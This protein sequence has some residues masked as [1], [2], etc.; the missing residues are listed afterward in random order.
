MKMNAADF[1]NYFK[2][3]Y[4]LD[5]KEFTINNLLSNKYPFKWFVNGREEL[6]HDATPLIPYTNKKVLDLEKELQLYQYEFSLFYGCFFIVGKNDNPLFSTEEKYCAPLLLFPA[7]I[8]TLDE[9]KFLKIDRSS[10]VINRTILSKLHLKDERISR[11]LFVQELTEIVDSAADNSIL[12]KGIFDKFFLNIHTDELNLFPAVWSPAKIKKH[13]STN[14][15]SDDQFQI[16]PAAGTILIN[17]SESSLKVIHDLDEIAQENTFN[18]SLHELLS[19][20][21]K[22]YPPHSSFYK[23]RLNTD[24]Y[25]ALQN[26]HQFSN[27]VIVGPPGTGK[28]YTITSIVADAVLHNQSVLIVSKTKQAVEVLR[29]MLQEDFNLKNYLIHTSGH[30]YKISLKS[31][32][33]KYLSGISPRAIDRSTE[34][35]L[36]DLF[37]KLDRLE[38]KFEKF[39]KRELT[40]TE[41]EQDD[42]LH[43]FQKWRKLYLKNISED[44]EKL[45]NYFSEINELLVRIQGQVSTFTMKKI[46][47]NINHHAKTYRKDLSLFLDAL[48]SAS[49][50]EY[51]RILTD[52]KQANILKVFPVWL[53]NLSELNSVLPLE[54]DLFDLVIIDEATQCDVATALPALY[55]AKRSVVVGDPNQ[56]RHYSFVSVQQQTNLH[57]EFNLPKDR[58]FDYR[59]KSILDVFISKVPNQQQISFL[60]EHFRSTPS[61]IEFSNQHFYGGQLEVMKSTPEYANASQIAIID[62]HG[63]RSEKGINE[64]EAHALLKKLDELIADYT[65]HQSVPSI[66]IVS[67]FSSQ[68]SFINSLI[69][70]K[71]DL[72]LLKKFNLLCGTP[73]NFQ[74]AERDIVLI[75]FCVCDN[76]H[77]SA[78][79]HASKAEVLNVA[80]T[81]AKSFQYIFKSVAEKNMKPNSLLRQYFLFINQYTPDAKTVLL[82]DAFQQRVCLA[83][84]EKGFN[85]IKTG[86][87]IAGN[88]LDIFISH[89]N[90]NYFIDLIGYPGAY[91]DAFSMERYRTLARTGIKSMP[92]H[93]TFWQKNPDKALEKLIAF[94]NSHSFF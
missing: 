29:N 77:A 57:S 13:L 2:E 62:T 43:L 28:T 40:I 8:I 44:S 19:D 34:T 1:Y 38:L 17:K 56:L 24:Q 71:Y 70:E 59:N 66:G 69:K 51:K 25:I 39:V 79:L 84:E 49:F 61:L 52:V 30:S 54:R 6:Y 91:K 37:D 12:I 58:I 73:Y 80:I 53:A 78:F 63:K 26:A 20:T 47:E 81:R 72:A 14:I 42:R 5:N 11:D 76:T 27:S 64:V 85:S 35:R 88:V 16:V 41:L 90:K 83:L 48:D 46:R 68:V 31:K 3:C 22:E 92:L 60:R 9:E 4:K 21:A 89:N 74:G 87:P 82:A 93:Y 50:T 10:L 18:S 94:L 67:P 7:E 36:E 15:F 75:S 45:W 33:K 55:R 23:S 65:L 86:Y 32:I